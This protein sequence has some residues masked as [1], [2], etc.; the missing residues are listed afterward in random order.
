MA[1]KSLKRIELSD[2]P[3]TGVGQSHSHGT[4]Q[5]PSTNDQMQWKLGKLS[6]DE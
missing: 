4:M 1:P 5:N 3:S 2:T 6:R